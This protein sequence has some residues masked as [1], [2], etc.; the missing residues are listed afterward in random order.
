MTV[1]AVWGMKPTDDMKLTLQVCDAE[2]DEAA[3][4]AEDVGGGR[5]V[6]LKIFVVD[7]AEDVGGG[8]QLLLK[9]LED[10]AED[11]GGGRQLLKMLVEEC[12]C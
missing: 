1:V 12:S 2:A 6:L 8:M 9:M 3:D 7:A 11:V 10:A 4:V 5:Q